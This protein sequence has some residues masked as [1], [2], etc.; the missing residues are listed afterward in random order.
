MI[1]DKLFL[2]NS[3]EIFQKKCYSCSQ[4]NHFV[5]DCPLIQ[6]KPNKFKFLNEYF[7]IEKKKRKTFLRKRI[8][9]INSLFINQSILR[10]LIFKNYIKFSIKKILL[11]FLFFFF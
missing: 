3:N 8:Y 5:L 11:K 4:L 1:K 10:L 7:Q 9:K 2:Y 6:Y